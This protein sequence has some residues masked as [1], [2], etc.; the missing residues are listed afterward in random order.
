MPS[1]SSELVV[2]SGFYSPAMIGV[3][4]TS[5]EQSFEASSLQL[6]ILQNL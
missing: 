2:A 1:N 6:L 5:F 4:I 3:I